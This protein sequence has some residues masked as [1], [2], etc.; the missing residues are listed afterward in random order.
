MYPDQA[1]QQISHESIYSAIYLMP[2]GELR[3][4]ITNALRQS[5]QK[6]MPRARGVACKGNI[7][8]LIPLSERP[9]EADD[10]VVPGHWENDFIK[11]ARNAS[12]IA[13]ALER[14]SRFML[15]TQMN[16]C[17][18]AHGL[19]GFTR[20]FKGVIPELRKTFTDERGSRIEDRRWRAI[21]S[22]RLRRALMF[23]FAISTALGSADR[24]ET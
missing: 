2:R 9:V 21:R 7:T 18:A 8:N 15:L 11:G 24:T 16:G 14:T 4:E 12:A 19:E 22:S 10:R 20:R 13:T 3:T 5:R 6:R 17:T 1:E 23:I